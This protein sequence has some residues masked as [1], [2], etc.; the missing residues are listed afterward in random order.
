MRRSSD[1]SVKRIKS[2]ANNA[3]VQEG[4]ERGQKRQPRQIG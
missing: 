2:R 1:R 3:W 4:V